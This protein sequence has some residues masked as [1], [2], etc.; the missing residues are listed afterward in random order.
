[1]S[2]LNVQILVKRE[3]RFKKAQD[4]LQEQ[5]RVSAQAEWANKHVTS[6]HKEADERIRKQCEEELLMQNEKIKRTRR[7][8][9]K[10]LYEADL[11]RWKENLADLGLAITEE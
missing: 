4:A 8:K 1:M 11:A 7:Q 5:L 2:D 3:M 6:S 9:L 10:E